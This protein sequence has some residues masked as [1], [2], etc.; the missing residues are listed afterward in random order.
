MLDGIRL[1]E[2]AHREGKI[3]I[4][5]Y[6]YA[7]DQ[8]IRG[9]IDADAASVMITKDMYFLGKVEESVAQSS[10]L[11]KE[12]IERAG[13]SVE[14][15]TDS[16]KTS[17]VVVEE[18]SRE[19]V[20]TGTSAVSAKD[21]LAKMKEMEKAAA[22]ETKRLKS[23]L[24]K[25]NEEM[26]Q[27]EFLINGPVA[28]A[29]TG[30]S[31]AQSDI[32]KDI[33]DY[34][35][36]IRELGGLQY[37]SDEDIGKINTLRGELASA[38]GELVRL[39]EIIKASE[40]RDTKAGKK[41]GFDLIP[42]KKI[43]AAK[44]KLQE[45]RNTIGELQRELEAM[46]V[47]PNI[48]KEDLEK[49]QE[50]QTK[51]DEATLA[52]DAE[53][54]AFKRNTSEIIF[55]MAQKQIAAAVEA[56][57]IK[58]TN[59]SGTAYDEASRAMTVLAVQMGLIDE[60]TAAL[61]TSVVD[62]TG[63]FID[64]KISLYEW[65]RQLLGDRD[66]VTGYKGDVDGLDNALRGLPSNVKTTYT[67]EYKIKGEPSGAFEV[68]IPQPK[69]GPAPKPKGEA[70][71]GPVAPNTPY[72]VGEYGPELFVP[73]AYG[74][75]LSVFDLPSQSKDTPSQKP[76]MDALNETVSPNQN[77]RVPELFMLSDYN[78]ANPTHDTEP[79]QSKIPAPKPKTKMLG[80]PVSRNQPWE[81][82]ELFMPLD[83][84]KTNPIPNIDEKSSNQPINVTIYAN[85]NNDVDVKMLAYQVA[86]EISRRQ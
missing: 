72:W 40:E 60:S 13:G 65:A 63:A 38:F 34:K 1:V 70:L 31:E 68:P 45:L 29:Y 56:G 78:K 76:K 24:S 41:G 11:M 27:L 50:L 84:N 80:D 2:T 48:K 35:K 51:I 79:L 3:S 58:D 15:F 26:G 23:E 47:S 59:N 5:T 55:N 8:L 37:V 64:G 20:K 85:L 82:S 62:T 17:T 44:E 83:Y 22:E 46:G 81:L 77:W 39:Q 18:F 25:F 67:L 57:L 52:L 66:I 49:I 71:G 10:G 42:P 32:K 28:E 19:L 16:S 74:K 30:F 6:A 9:V 12:E 4:L 75:I 61:Q 73:P 86:N 14:G 43:D 69:G 54:E 21:A 7:M 36:E 33:I 53:S